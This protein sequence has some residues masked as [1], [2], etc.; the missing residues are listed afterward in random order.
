ME[1]LFN[2]FY[3]GIHVKQAIKDTIEQCMA[4][5]ANKVIIKP[6]LDYTPISNPKHPGLIF[7]IDVMKRHQQKI[8]VCPLFSWNAVA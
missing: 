2:R 5:K 4:C 8:M 1:K 6:K 7:N 3:Y